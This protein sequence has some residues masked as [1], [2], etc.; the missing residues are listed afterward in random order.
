MM[1]YRV[2]IDGSDGH[3]IS[4]EPLECADDAAAMEQQS[5]LLTATTLSFGSATA[6]WLRSTISRKCNSN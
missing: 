5:S 4:L 3:F 2:Y 1:E 6:G